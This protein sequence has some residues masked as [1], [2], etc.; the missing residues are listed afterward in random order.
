M[1]GNVLRRR[2]FSRRRENGGVAILLAAILLVS[3][4][5]PVRAG[6]GPDDIRALVVERALA[7]GANAA[8]LVTTIGCESQ[9]DPRAVGAQGELGLTQLHPQGL[10]PSFYK[11]GYRDVWSAE[12]QADFAALM[13]ASGQAYHWSGWWVCVKGMTPPWWN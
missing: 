8:A 1:S 3:L 7:H 5:L 4:A 10:L 13:F 9:F 11:L 12:Q 6:G 2:P